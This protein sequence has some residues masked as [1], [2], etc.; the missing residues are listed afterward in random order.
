MPNVWTHIL[1]GVEALDRIGEGAM[2]GDERKRRLFQLGCQGP[3]FLFYHHF[4][5]WKRGDAMN[6]LGEAMHDRHCGP[7]L[8]ELLDGV[9]GRSADR[10]SPDDAVVYALGFVLHHTLDRNVHPYVFS[11]S[12]F[13]KWD[14]QRFEVMMDTIVMRRKRGIETWRTPVWRELDA[15]RALPEA[16]V[17][18]FERIAARYY[19]ELAATIRREDW[20]RACRDMIGAQRLFHDPTGIRRLLTFGKIGPF[21]YRRRLPDLDVLN[22]AGRPWLDP[23]DGMTRRADTF[24]QLWDRAMDESVD[25][26]R[27]AL[28]WLR[29]ESGEADAGRDSARAAE[30]RG[31]T[32]VLIGNRSYETGLDCGAAVIRYADPIWPDGCGARPEEAPPA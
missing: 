12:G 21:V 18:A 17:D 29:H 6:R 7:V 23:T 3:D 13:R 20:N 4:L 24:D 14:H 22:D 16:I 10:T 2:I 19:P 26:L 15:G 28:E 32:A 27:A 30:W 9:A 5:P 1:F 8:M 31:R 11:R 25:I